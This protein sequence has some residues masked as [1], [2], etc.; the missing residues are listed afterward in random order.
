MADAIGAQ[1]IAVATGRYSVEELAQHNPL[2][3]FA[4]LTDT[5]AIMRAI[6]AA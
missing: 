3:V 4:D 5:S 2:A 6:D 1:A